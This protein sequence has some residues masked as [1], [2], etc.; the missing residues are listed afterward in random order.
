MYIDSNVQEFV[1]NG[2]PNK[3]A[4]IHIMDKCLTGGKPLPEPLMV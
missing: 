3:V 4:L 1:S 2:A